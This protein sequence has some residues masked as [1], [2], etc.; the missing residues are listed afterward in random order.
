MLSDWLTSGGFG[1]NQ[2]IKLFEI[3][4]DPSKAPKRVWNKWVFKVIKKLMWK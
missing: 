4:K 2:W 3:V 1:S